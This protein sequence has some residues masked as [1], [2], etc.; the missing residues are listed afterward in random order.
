MV[1]DKT[2]YDLVSDEDENRDLC[3][4][5]P[6]A[7]PAP[8]GMAAAAAAIGIAG[9]TQLSAPVEATQLDMGIGS[10]PEGVRTQE[11]ALERWEWQWAY[12]HK[13][14]VDSTVD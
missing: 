10:A 12:G 3:Y 1:Q 13:Y 11:P 7:G 6:C 9:S 4:I 2:K 5:C 14:T 8:L